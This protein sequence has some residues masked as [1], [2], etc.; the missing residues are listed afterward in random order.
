MNGDVCMQIYLTVNLVF[1]IPVENEKHSLPTVLVCRF[2]LGLLDINIYTLHETLITYLAP[3]TVDHVGI[4]FLL[5]NVPQRSGSG[6]RFDVIIFALNVFDLNCYL[7]KQ[8]SSNCFKNAV[9]SPDPENQFEYL[10]WFRYCI[11]GPIK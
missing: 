2:Y 3:N 10:R 8:H 4:V 6:P 5:F 9:L 1:S 11:F 7:T